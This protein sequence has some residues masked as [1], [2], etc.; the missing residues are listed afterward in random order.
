MGEVFKAEKM[1]QSKEA[2]INKADAK[3]FTALHLALGHKQACGI[4]IH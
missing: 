2:D 1:I 3:G 4:P